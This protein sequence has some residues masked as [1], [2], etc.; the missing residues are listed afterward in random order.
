[1]K[2]VWD[3]WLRFLSCFNKPIEYI[4]FF[5]ILASLVL[6]AFLMLLI[7]ICEFKYLYYIKGATL[8]AKE[9]TT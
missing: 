7:Y 3:L 4:W 1:M 9:S 8:K 6:V 5:L 2:A